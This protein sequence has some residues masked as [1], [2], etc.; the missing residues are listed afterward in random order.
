MILVFL[1]LV[2]PSPGRGTGG[3]AGTAPGQQPAEAGCACRV[4]DPEAVHALAKLL[5]AAVRAR[6]GEKKL[7]SVTDEISRTHI[8]Y[9]DVYKSEILLK[10]W[11]MEPYCFRQDMIRDGIILKSQQVNGKTFLEGCGRRVLFGLEKDRKVFL[12]NLELNRIFSLLCIGTESYPA[13][14][15][16]RMRQED[17]WLQEVIVKA[18]SGLTYR[19]FFDEATCLIARLEYVERTQYARGMEAYPMVTLIDSYRNVDG[20][21][22][23][24]RLRILS[25]GSLKAEVRLIEYAFNTG[26]TAGF[27]SRK[28]LQRDLA[29]GP[30][31]RG[32]GTGPGPVE[33]TWKESAYTK[34]AQRLQTHENCRFREVASYGDPGKYRKRLF[35]SG[36]SLVVDPTYLQGDDTLAFYAELLP[37]PSGFY[38]DCIVLAAPPQD[39]PVSAAL[40]LH[41]TTHAILWQGREQER[42]RVADDEYFTFYQGSL[43]GVGRLLASFERI[44]FHGQGAQDPGISERAAGTWRAAARNLRR[45]RVQ[46][47]MTPEAV[48]QF[49]KW[50]G[51]DFDLNKIREHYLALGADP[52]WMPMESGSP[53]P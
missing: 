53:A 16:R 26:L 1:S 47:R 7:G 49:R 5:S 6:G 21:L 29:E 28:R 30:A 48:A 12:E 31:V 37:A 50:C 3:G 22:V 18:P 35:E 40:L 38:Q 42:L 25:Q 24:D 39:P 51:V 20:V 15:G 41:E 11:R 10:T 9:G 17:R 27:F 32:H 43:F 8:V 36:L 23:A 19:V 45:N 4:G 44:V 46:N 13:S 52:K 14:L 33:R 34:I 2:S